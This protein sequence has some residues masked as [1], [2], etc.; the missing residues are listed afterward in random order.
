MSLSTSYPNDS[1]SGETIKNFRQQIHC[2]Q[3]GYKN[4]MWW[5]AHI[6]NWFT[7]L[8]IKENCH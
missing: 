4:E 3:Y 8:L 6:Y 2:Q 7:V 5:I 1:H